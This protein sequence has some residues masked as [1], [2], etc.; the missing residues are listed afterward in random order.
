[1]EFFQG[2]RRLDSLTV[3]QFELMVASHVVLTFTG[4]KNAVRGER[5]AQSTSGDPLFALFGH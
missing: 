5:V 2:A 3:S 1:M 4:Q